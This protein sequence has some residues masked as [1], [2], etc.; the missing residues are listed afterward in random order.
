MFFITG[1]ICSACCHREWEPRLNFLLSLGDLF[2]GSESSKYMVGHVQITGLW[3]GCT[4]SQRRKKESGP[5]PAVM[6]GGKNT[7]NPREGEVVFQEGTR[8]LVGKGNKCWAIKNGKYQ[9]FHFFNILI[10]DFLDI[11]C[12]LASLY[13]T[14]VNFKTQS[15]VFCFVISVLYVGQVIVLLSS[16]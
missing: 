10:L 15:E 2:R 14:C 7:S 12:H 13:L 5:S 1:S 6:G 9:L 8:V 3:S 16:E 4:R 11:A